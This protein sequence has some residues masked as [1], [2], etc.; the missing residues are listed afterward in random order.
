MI[1][2]KP[3]KK[4]KRSS[5][6]FPTKPGV[7]FKKLNEIAAKAALDRELKVLP[8]KRTAEKTTVPDAADNKGDK[9]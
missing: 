6:I 1:P 9:E 4:A 2:S 7:G 3:N 5:P 8:N